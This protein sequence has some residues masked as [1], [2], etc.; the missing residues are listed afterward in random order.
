MRA[1]R[2]AQIPSGHDETPRAFA[3]RHALAAIVAWYDVITADLGAL[4]DAHDITGPHRCVAFTVGVDHAPNPDGEHVW[5]E[6]LREVALV[7]LD[8]EVTLTAASNPETSA[9][10]DAVSLWL[11]LC[12]A[13]STLAAEE[14]DPCMILDV[15]NRVLAS[16]PA[17]YCPDFG[18]HPST[19]QLVPTVESL[20]AAPDPFEQLLA[21]DPEAELDDAYE[22]L[23]ATMELHALEAPS[24]PAHAPGDCDLY[25]DEDEEDE[26]H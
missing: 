12:A 3:Q 20:A 8:N 13:A 15:D 1:Q 17:Y 14:L 11:D 19:L 24:T 21:A 22:Q 23:I 25:D 18:P 16:W 26:G 9:W 6:S 4:M 5:T 2:P 7:G 10:P